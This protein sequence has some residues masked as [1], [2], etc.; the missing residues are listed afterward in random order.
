MNRYK[1]YTRE[2]LVANVNYLVKQGVV[3][4]SNG[5]RDLNREKYRYEPSDEPDDDDYDAEATERK[6]IPRYTPDNPSAKSYT[7]RLT[8]PDKSKNNWDVVDIPINA[9]DP[10][11][12]KNMALVKKIINLIM[13][14]RPR[15]AEYITITSR[16]RNVPYNKEKGGVQGSLHQWGAAVDLSTSNPQEVTVKDIMN[17]IHELKDKNAALYELLG[18]VLYE[19][20]HVHITPKGIFRTTDET[21]QLFRQ[22]FSALSPHTWSEEPLPEGHPLAAPAAAT[23]T[24]ATPV[25]DPAPEEEESVEEPAPEP[26]QQETSPEIKAWYKKRDDLKME[27]AAAKQEFNQLVGS[28]KKGMK[29]R[30]LQNVYADV[31]PE[32]FKSLNPIE[33][34]R[35]KDLY[36]S[37]YNSY[38]NVLERLQ[39]I[40]DHR[41]RAPEG[42][43]YQRATTPPLSPPGGSVNEARKIRSLIVREVRN[44][45][46]P[47]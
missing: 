35:I 16:Y 47:T 10:R 17:Y 11:V 24:P 12:K 44:L 39:E 7:W 40:E 31:S 9:E 4:D 8:D 5:S 25:E 15:A 21:D 18:I 23:T 37:L 26:V 20:D 34:E 2:E 29:M 36:E 45:L 32:E 14:G 3:V 46:D 22:G 41:K 1:A 27:H 6:I 33:P 42:L 13:N 30:M 43:A 38:K 28:L 19:G